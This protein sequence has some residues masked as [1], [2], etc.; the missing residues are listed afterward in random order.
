M[1]NTKLTTKDKQT[2]R[3]FYNKTNNKNYT[4]ISRI[5]KSLG[6]SSAESYELL[7]ELYNNALPKPKPKLPFTNQQLA[8]GK[9]NLKKLYTVKIDMTL[10]YSYKNKSGEASTRAYVTDNNKITSNQ[11]FRA[12]NINELRNLVDQYVESYNLE[13]SEAIATLESHSYSILDRNVSNMALTDSR[14]LMR[15]D[16]IVRKD[17]LKYSQN[18]AKTAFEQSGNE[19]GYHQLSNFLNNPPTGNKKEYIGHRSKGLK[20]DKEGLFKFFKDNIDE[21]EYPNFNIKTGIT[22]EMIEIYCRFENRSFYG[23]NG[24]D[25]CFTHFVGDS[26]NYCPIVFYKTNGH[27][28]LIDDPKCY[29]SIAQTMNVVTKHLSSRGNVDECKFAIDD[30]NSQ[31]IYLEQFDC[32]NALQMQSGRYVLPVTDLMPHFVDMIRQHRV[33]CMTGSKQH[34]IVRMFFSNNNKE[35]V[36]LSAFAYNVGMQGLAHKYDSKQAFDLIVAESNNIG[37]EYHNES[38]SQIISEV[39]NAVDGVKKRINITSEISKQ[40]HAKSKNLCAVC[41]LKASSYEIDHIQPLSAGGTNDISNLQI[42]CYDCHQDKTIHEK[43]NNEH[44]I[45]NCTL[46]SF[47]SVV[48]DKIINT[49]HFKSYQFVEKVQESNQFTCNV[50]KIDTIKCRRNLLYYSKY[51]F[52]VYSVM[53]YPQPFAGNITCGYYYVNTQNTFPMRGCGWYCQGMVEYCFHRGLIDLCDIEYELIPSNKLPATHFRKYIDYILTHVQNKDLQKLLPNAMIGCWGIMT[54]TKTHSKFSI[55][56]TEASNWFTNKGSFFRQ[57]DIGLDD[58]KLYECEYISETVCPTNEYPLYNMILQLEACN[59]HNLEYIIKR[60]GGKI[61]DRNTDAIRYAGKKINLDRFFWD[62]EKTVPKY[63]EENPKALEHESMPQFKRNPMKYEF[64]LQWKN[65]QMTPQEIYDLKEGML[66][67]G[68]AGT[69]KTYFVNSL[70]E[71]LKQNKH[72]YECLAPTNKSAKLVNGMVL[73]KLLYYNAKS[74][75]NWASRMQY[76]IVDEISM[77]KEI[78]YNLLSNI[79]L[80][81]PKIIFYICGDFEQLEPVKDKWHGDYSNSPVLFNLCNNNKLVLTECKRSDTALFNLCLDVNKVDVKQLPVVQ[82]TNLNLALTHETRKRV[83]EKCM[84]NALKN[85]TIKPFEI[86]ADTCNPK[87][88]NVKLI[89]NMPLIAHKNS[90][91]LKII[92]T[93][94]FKLVSINN[95]KFVVKSLS[96]GEETTV[97]TSLFHKLFYLAYCITVHSSQGETFDEKFTIYDWNHPF[98]STKAKYVALSRGKTVSQIQ[99]VT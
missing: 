73:D 22:A 80:I 21:D 83:N 64:K 1:N 87:T 52:P 60:N 17:W 58:I 82:E 10:A 16:F 93:D 13:G 35:P 89:P 2:L 34:K 90:K 23:F 6:V 97:K 49:M 65:Q 9:T 68:R 19:C 51:E 14:Q 75:K 94:R 78:F 39:V 29:K 24:D 15:D 67:N 28:F 18:I 32:A 7:R 59:L 54:K 92:N 66:I 4:S 45:D 72:T 31:L 46:S 57:H 42:L 3:E 5:S 25:K 36:Y 11:T 33:M 48:L 74:L 40:V 81:N 85:S 86:A 30:K 37:F 44:K 41:N 61:L 53:D 99:I 70:V 98:F 50:N 8:T 62:D 38:I 63:Q 71:I 69:G 79:K 95:D 20:T 96:T 77:V 55:D 84:M 91:S 76:I 43:S 12:S 88:Q 47:N 26:K 27:M 56:P